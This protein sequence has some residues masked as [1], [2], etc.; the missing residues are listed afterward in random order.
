MPA[1][2]YLH[3]VMVM[4]LMVDGDGVDDDGDEDGNEI[5]LSGVESRI[6]LTPEMKIMVV[7]A[8]HI[9]NRSPPLGLRVFH[10]YEEVCERGD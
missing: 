9:A 6:N 4:K 10:I 1:G 2:N 8:L 7:A 3:M 5:P